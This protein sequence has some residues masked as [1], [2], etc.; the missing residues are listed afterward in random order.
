MDNVGRV[1]LLAYGD[2]DLGIGLTVG[3]RHVR[4]ALVARQRQTSNVLFSDARQAGVNQAEH[5]HAIVLLVT[6]AITVMAIH[7]VGGMQRKVRA[8]APQLNASIAVPH[9]RSKPRHRVFD[10]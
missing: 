9:L 2:K 4:N 8:E 5:D 7:A 6:A 3:E 1:C 10:D